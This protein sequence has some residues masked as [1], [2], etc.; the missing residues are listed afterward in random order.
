MRGG[1]KVDEAF[2]LSMRCSTQ[3]W[4]GTTD[5]F[6]NSDRSGSVTERSYNGCLAGVDGLVDANI[7]GSVKIAR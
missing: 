3:P 1:G 2:L 6:R 4:Y 5:G 7:V